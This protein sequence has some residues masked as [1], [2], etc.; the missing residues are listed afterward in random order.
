MKNNCLSI[1]SWSVKT[2]R[3]RTI[4]APAFDHCFRW[5][6]SLQEIGFVRGSL[7]NMHDYKCFYLP[8]TRIKSDGGVLIYVRNIYQLGNSCKKR[9]GLNLIY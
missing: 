1:L 5:M 9:M 7:M 8:A 3:P 6:S 2:L 4:E